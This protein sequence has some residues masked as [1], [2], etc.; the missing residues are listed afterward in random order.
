VL[1]RGLANDV[2]AIQQIDIEIIGAG[3]ADADRDSVKT[4]WW[5]LKGVLA[6]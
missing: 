1:D 4:A 6:F 2:G 3:I 5:N